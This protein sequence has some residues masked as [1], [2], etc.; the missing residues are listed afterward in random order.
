M[1]RLARIS[2]TLRGI[3]LVWRWRK[4]IECHGSIW[5]CQNIDRPNDNHQ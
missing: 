3:F 1:K 2:E 4:R 5:C